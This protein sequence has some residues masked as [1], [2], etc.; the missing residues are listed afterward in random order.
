[1]AEFRKG[2]VLPN[3]A[4]VLHDPARL[5]AVDA[6]RAIDEQTGAAFARSVNLAV[7]LLNADKALISL[8]G[9]DRQ[10]VRGG[11]GTAVPRHGEQKR[12]GW[13]FC[14]EV[15][16]SSRPLVIDDVQDDPEH[17][18]D[19]S[20]AATGL[21]AYLGVPLLLEELPIGALCVIDARPRPWNTEEKR[22][23]EQLSESVTSEIELRLD[24][25]ERDRLYAQTAVT[26]V[27]ERRR[28]QQ[29][30]DLARSSLRIN[31]APSLDQSLQTVTEE[32]RALVGT[33]QS[34]TSMTTNL[35]WGQAINAISLS[36]KYAEY[37]SFDAPPVGE[38]IY[39]LVCRNNRPMR[40]TQD[41]LEAHPA[42]RGFGAYAAQHPPMRGWLAVPLITSDGR[43]LGLI[44]LSD[45]ED[46]SDF[47]ADDEAI[48]VQLAQLASASIEKAAALESQYEIART[49][50]SSLLPQRL[51]EQ[52]AVSAASRYLPATP[53]AGVGGDWFD[54]IGLSGAR[55][56]LVVGDVVG[57]GI[58]AAATMGRLRTAVRTLADVDPTPEELLTRLD[59]LVSR[60]PAESG[61]DDDD[62]L[63]IEGEAAL[64][65]TCLYAVYD[66]VAGRCALACAGHPVPVIV[67]P[68]GRAQ[69]LDVPVGPPL[70]VGG[71][72]FETAEVD[73]PEG[74][75]LAF[76]TDGLVESRNRDLD[77][78]LEELR[79]TLAEPYDSLEELCDD[80][81]KALLPEP[82]ADDA[83]LLLV[84]PHGLDKARV[85]TW[86]IA[87][88]PAEVARARARV[89]H[90][91]TTGGLDEVGF[92]TEL[93]V[94][95][96]VTNAIRYGRPPLQLRLIYDRT[97]ICEVSDTSSTA[98][99]LRRAAAFDEGGRG[100]MLVAQ[101]TQRWGTRHAHEGK[102]IWCEQALPTAGPLPDHH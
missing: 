68:D 9:A 4:M 21:R 102:T 50:Q 24:A 2:D 36:D 52:S 59:D 98:P 64:G 18:A 39:V 47:T 93:V 5:A 86:D 65:A 75:L 49:L 16:A 57:H 38:G 95:E 17:R 62:R 84:R 85:A 34:I 80:V 81:L 11:A 33:H 23:L 82:P 29:L 46:G 63:G 76:Y 55:V 88:E 37:R 48:L 90:T 53:R 31:T 60:P 78:G 8:A 72:P 42:W 22:A 1:M 94:S 28:S 56:A 25:A 71:V 27:V 51:P 77:A 69:F 61:T 14:S 67:A 35:H 58:N 32:A 43:N 73:V 10:Y 26:A 101:L 7:R 100:L 3:P 70:G 15:V 79:R 19:G 44:Q 13:A 45:K 74:S 54:V 87:A 97:V 41:Q 30:Q 91:L 89:A 92:V 12:L 6:V 20:V 40:M 99:H 66:P 83:A 96:L